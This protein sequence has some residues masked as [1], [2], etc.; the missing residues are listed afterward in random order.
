[1][2]F[3]AVAALMG[4]TSAIN[5]VP[6][7]KNTV[8]I[9]S[10][11][12]IAKHI[13]AKYFGAGEHV[14]IADMSDAQYFIQVTLGTPPQEFTVVPDTGSSNLWIYA[15]NCNAIPCWY[16]PRFDASK[17]TSYKKNGEDFIIQY[18]SGGING[19][20][21][22][23]IAT[24]G[25]ISAPMGFGEVMGVSGISFY[26]SKMSGILGMAYDSISVDSLPTWLSSAAIKDKSFSM[27]LHSNPTK[28]YMVI[29]GMDSENFSTMQ[30][31]KV[32]EEKYW[33][34]Q[35]TSM[36]KGD[37]KPIDT[38]QY[39]AVID[40]GTS[41]LVGP[42]ALVN[43]L[44]QGIAVMGDC[45]N[46]DTL[47]TIN[48]KIDQTDY[49]ITS[50]DYVLMETSAGQSQCTMGIA[51]MPMPVGFNYFIFG[52]VFMRK[53]PAYFNRNDNTVS[54]QVANDSDWYLY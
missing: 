44:I 31:H 42:Q 9:E 53:Y 7:E 17:S 4:L 33:A 2:K 39:K 12:N 24:I 52:D 40:S 50:R 11:K 30:T 26:A 35:F 28:S 36:Q 23:D 3:S 16:H 45:S 43:P 19:T 6:I 15:E 47:P 18:G 5:R 51:A 14:D 8:S 37:E 38:T 41:L 27:Y 46:I 54:F 34:L 48:L 21:G 29:P 22:E 49:P 13:E 10:R 32:V 1:M 25:D 20:V